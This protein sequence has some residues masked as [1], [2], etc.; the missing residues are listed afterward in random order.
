M[1][2]MINNCKSF[3]KN[4]RAIEKTVKYYLLHQEQKMGIPLSIGYNH[5]SSSLSVM[6]S[7][8]LLL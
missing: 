8:D 4:K 5:R 7:L 2:L 6:D 3:N 1:A